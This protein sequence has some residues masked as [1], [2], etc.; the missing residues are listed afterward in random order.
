[1]VISLAHYLTVAAILFLLLTIPMTRFTD[2]LVARDR[3]RRLAGV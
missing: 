3:T 2:H 1:M